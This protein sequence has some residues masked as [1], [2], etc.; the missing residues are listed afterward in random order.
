MNEE[1]G[2]E[3]VDM[4]ALLRQAAEAFAYPPTPG[5]AGAVTARLREPAPSPLASL[6]GRLSEI[7]RGWWG[8]PVPRVAIALLT[9]ALAVIGIALAIP[10][11]RTALAE[12]FG[13]SHVRVEQEPSL[14]PPPP[15]LSP[16]RF[17][18]PVSL[19]Q[20]QELVD[21]PLRFPTRD[22][23]SLRPDAAYLRGE[24]V[25]APVVIFVYEDEGFDLYQTRQGFLGKGGTDP[26][27]I[28]EIEFGGRPALWIDEGGHIASF[29]DE[30]G[31][32]MVESRRTVERATLLWEESG[33]T[34]RLETALSQEEA[35]RLAESL[36]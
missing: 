24:E 3:I 18:R 8:R 20:A 35:I 27:L 26:S 12:F 28:H 13:L 15:I 29:L 14:G 19:G 22:G 30:Q 21:F 23:P 1:L 6:A 32:V 36:L 7:V 34:Y 10:Q 17:A 2:P 5:I 9:A 33:I 25:N 11:S 31:R 4:D 16:D